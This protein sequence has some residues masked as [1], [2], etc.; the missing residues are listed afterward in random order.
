MEPAEVKVY[1]ENQRRV[2]SALCLMHSKLM[3]FHER[4]SQLTD[5]LLDSHSLT[6]EF[7]QELKKDT[8]LVALQANYIHQ[9][10]EFVKAQLLYTVNTNLVHQ[11]EIADLQK[12]LEPQSTPDVD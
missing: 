10:T 9:Q 6:E 3:E 12:R 7:K 11:A 4:H 2:L 1:M 5:K 8:Q